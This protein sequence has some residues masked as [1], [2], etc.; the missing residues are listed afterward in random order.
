M[1]GAQEIVVLKQHVTSLLNAFWSWWVAQKCPF[2]RAL[3]STA[4]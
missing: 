3:S 2:W 1:A 4:S